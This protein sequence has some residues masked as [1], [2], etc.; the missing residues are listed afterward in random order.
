[1]RKL[2]KFQQRVMNHL[3]KGGWLSSSIGGWYFNQKKLKVETEDRLWSTG[4][5][6]EVKVQGKRISESKIIHKS[7]FNPEIHTIR[8]EP[9]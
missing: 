3:L 5:L 7:Q 8:K 4:E 1:M 9:S 6:I 2:G